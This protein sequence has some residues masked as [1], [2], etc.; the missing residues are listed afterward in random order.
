MTYV[1]MLDRS[2]LF[3]SRLIFPLILTVFM[4]LFATSIFGYSIAKHK[5]CSLGL[6]GGSCTTNPDTLAY[7]LEFKLNYANIHTIHVA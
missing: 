3:V 4:I 5:V 6:L 7:K 1:R 2:F